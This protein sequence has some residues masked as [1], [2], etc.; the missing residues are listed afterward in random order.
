MGVYP[1]LKMGGNA[2]CSLRGHVLW[3]T[4]YRHTGQ[5]QRNI[6]EDGVNGLLIEPEQPAQMAEALRR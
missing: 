2:K 3:C 1:P 4:F 6:I 5:W